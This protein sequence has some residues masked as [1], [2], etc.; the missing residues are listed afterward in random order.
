MAPR[1]NRLA[2]AP[3]RRNVGRKDLDR[4]MALLN[5]LGDLR[6]QIGRDRALQHDM[7]AVVGKALPGPVLG[8]NVDRLLDGLARL[9]GSEIQQRG[10]AAVDRRPA[11]DVGAI[12]H[13]HLAALFELGDPDSV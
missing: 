9:P 4:G 12:G 6:Q 2:A 3:A 8:A 7:I 11:D 13:F 5:H 1:R 10:R